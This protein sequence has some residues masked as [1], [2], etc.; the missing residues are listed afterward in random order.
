MG[1]RGVASP[2]R[3]GAVGSITSMPLDPLQERI[4]RTALRLPEAHTL[5]LAGGAAMIAHGF[6]TRETKDVDLFTEID[7]QEAKRVA[8]G[9]R[10]A[11]E[12]HGLET[13][14]TERPPFDH[15]FVAVDPATG[16]ECTVE[17]LP[18]GGRLQ[19]RV[20]L[21]IGSVLHPDDL[22]ADK[23]LALWGRAR[24]RDFFDV[25]AL[26]DRYGPDR[27]LDLAATKDAGFT[28]ETFLDAL[29][30]I[31]RLTAADWAEDGISP[32]DA[33]RLRNVFDTWYAQLTSPI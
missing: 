12:Q 2:D 11:L 25:A 22:A 26:L 23:L 7:D 15:Q 20:L 5:A 4:A 21:D 33:D 19:P 6:V 9:L 18:D 1:A 13:R 32:Q 17:V 31:A 28:I 30:A 27:L 29:R 14:D 10:K 8:A 16:A 3:L 24:P